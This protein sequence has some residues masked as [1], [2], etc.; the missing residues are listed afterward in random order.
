MNKPTS[1]LR[2]VAGASLALCSALTHV[3]QAAPTQAELDSIVLYGSTTIA[4]DST[5]AWGVW[6]QIDPPAAGPASTTSP[7][8]SGTAPWRRSP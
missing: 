6:E 7:R 5:S 4:K 2:L 3:A 1:S 8:P